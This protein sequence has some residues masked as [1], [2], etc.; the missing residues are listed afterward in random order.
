MFAQG[1]S[2]KCSREYIL[3]QTSEE[4]ILSYYT[5]IN[6][7]PCVTN[8]PIREDKHPSFGV[9]YSTNGIDFT[10]YKTQAKVSENHF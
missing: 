8:S 4:N 5:G 10:D 9:Y 1:L 7:I 6:K 2:D 3:S